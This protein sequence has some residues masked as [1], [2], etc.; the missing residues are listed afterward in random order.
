MKLREAAVD[1]SSTLSCGK[2]QSQI[3][4]FPIVF[5]GWKTVT[6]N[7]H[8]IRTQ[9]AAVSAVGCA[10][11]RR[12]PEDWEKH[13]KTNDSIQKEFSVM[14]TH[15]CTRFFQDH[16]VT[17]GLHAGRGGGGL[18]LCCRL[19]TERKSGT[20][21]WADPYTSQNSAMWTADLLATLRSSAA[22]ESNPRW[23]MPSLPSK[24]KVC[25]IDPVKGKRH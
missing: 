13:Q 18:G 11:R 5:G 17:W 20:R 3:S 23:R 1:R 7:S 21:A 14:C 24:T 15:R 9:G 2:Q 25:K 8:K 6:R 19:E 12:A 16:G 22:C 10:R 4:E